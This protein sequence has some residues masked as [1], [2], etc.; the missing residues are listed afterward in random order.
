M[1][2]TI[3]ESF[4]TSFSGSGALAAAQHHQSVNLMYL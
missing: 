1:Q 3:A 2:R 4:S